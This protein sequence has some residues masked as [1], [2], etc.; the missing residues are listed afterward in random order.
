MADI[1]HTFNFSV[2]IA[3]GEGGDPLA[4][5]AFA[6]C[7]GLEASSGVK[8]IREGGNN[9]QPIH[10][11][12]PV[13]YGTLSLKRGMS[14]TFDLWNWFDRV[15]RDEEHHRRATCEIEVRSP[16]RKSVAYTIKLSGCLPVK[17]KAPDLNAKEG[18]LAIEE[19]EIAYETLKLVSPSGGGTGA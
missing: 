19:M 16:D 15:H 17:I 18:G 9:N 5:A 14:Q 4:E 13:S 2:R 6:E 1:H 11:V 3:L 7:T 10:L 8:T 12:G